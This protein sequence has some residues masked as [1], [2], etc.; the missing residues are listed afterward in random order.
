MFCMHNIHMAFPA[1]I[2][3]VWSY[4]NQ[5][6]TVHHL[7][8]YNLSVCWIPALFVH[9]HSTMFMQVWLAL[10]LGDGQYHFICRQY[11]VKVHCIE[12]KSVC[13]FGTYSPLLGGC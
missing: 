7:G 8:Y 13:I 4:H 2:S 9:N 11:L 10:I 6:F 12:D 3:C 1:L 5:L